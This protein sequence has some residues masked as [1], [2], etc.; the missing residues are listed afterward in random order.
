MSDR[1][2][3]RFVDDDAVVAVD[4]DTSLLEAAG[5][6]G[7]PVDSLCGGEGLCGTCA[8]DVEGG[9][10]HLSAPTDA[11]RTHLGAERL[12]DGRRLSC[13]CRVDTPGAVD[14]SIPLESRSE[15]ALVLT[16]GT[17]VEVDLDPAVT[18]HHVAVEPPSLA[19]PRSDRSRLL[20]AL[21][22]A[23][24]LEVSAI[25][26]A[27]LESLPRT[28]RAQETDTGL[29]VTAIVHDATELIDLRP[30]PDDAL[31]GLA[32]DVGTTTLA[33]YL[34]D[35][36]SGATVAVAS[37]LN[38]QRE[39]GEDIMSRM[40]YCR[41]H[42]DGREDLQAA[43]TAGINDL[44]DDL[45][46]SAAI[47]RERIYEAVLVGN[48]A[49]HHLALGIDPTHL[50]GAPYVPATDVIVAR[51]ARDLGID[52][53]PAGYCTW[54]PVSGGWVGP[55]AVAVALV[56]GHHDDA[57]RTTVCID[58]GTNGEISVAADGHTVA[59]SAPAG[60]ALEGAEL[61]CG[62][63]ARPGAIDHVDVDPETFAPSVSTIDDAAPVGICGS[64]VIDAVAACL[65]AGVVDHRGT[66][67]DAAA[68]SDH[69]REL[70][71][72]ELAYVLVP[73]RASATDA[74]IELT[75]NDIRDVQM[76]K[77]A[78][79]AATRVLLD[80]LDVDTV[81]RVVVAGGFGNHID[82]RAA[83]DVGLYPDVPD[84]AITS[85][86]NGAGVGAKRALLERGA[87][88]EAERL[89]DEIEYHEIA[90]T[91]AFEA[92]FLA[93]MYLPHQDLDSCPR[94]KARLEAQNPPAEVESAD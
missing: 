41:N 44:V 78:I 65:R 32:V 23:Y 38:P 54:L 91:D 48:T 3:V 40:R 9:T 17:E 72:G 68:A 2:E 71:S 6:A 39:H 47:D 86:G 73:E 82:P 80:E 55:D 75:Q 27:V 26:P 76:A 77:A 21:E 69:V 19:D 36:R 59:T 22:A 45:V 35:L 42:D 81:D 88:V 50:A 92:H 62:V 15:G 8:V 67:T 90:G 18:H 94:V 5:R 70:P 51:K 64:G 20:A 10:N 11:E 16:G 49:M 52:I 61:T 58:I 25:D 93:A 31:Y 13:R 84:D 28:L 74:P 37:A 29:S 7:V 53:N 60:P 30:G 83:V 1:A 87:R 66:F 89:V 14:V 33:A 34:L 56:A 85:L 12:D 24:D 79:Q 43:V 57:D 63:R 46:D 4:P